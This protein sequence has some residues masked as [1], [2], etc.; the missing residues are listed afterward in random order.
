[1][2]TFTIIL[3]QDSRVASG[4]DLSSYRR[5]DE[6]DDW[7]QA[8]FQEQSLGHTYEEACN[9]G[10]MPSLMTFALSSMALTLGRVPCMVP[11]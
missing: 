6:M 2:K 11:V 7:E 8:Y 4:V 3:I 1:M 10:M 5:K 9:L